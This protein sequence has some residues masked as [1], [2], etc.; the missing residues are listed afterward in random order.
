M[1]GPAISGSVS[2]P[3][4][5]AEAGLIY[6]TDWFH[7]DQPTPSG[8][9][10]DALYCPNAHSDDENANQELCRNSDCGNDF[11]GCHGLWNLY[12]RSSD[13]SRLSSYCNR[14]R[15]VHHCR[16]ARGLVNFHC[17]HV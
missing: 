8:W 7:D 16:P 1:L 3:D 5:M 2:T 17:C 11:R 12:T 13:C 14:R 15:R 6:H 4:L 10:G 9:P